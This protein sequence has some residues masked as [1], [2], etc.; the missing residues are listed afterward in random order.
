VPTARNYP[1]TG[2]DQAAAPV[3]ALARQDALELV[4]LLAVGAKHVSDLATAD[5][6][7][8]GGHIDVS[9]DVSAELAHE[10]DAEPSDLRV[11][12]AFG[13]EVGPALSA[14]HHHCQSG[15]ESAL[16]TPQFLANFLNSTLPLGGLLTSCEGILEYLLEAKEFEA[17][18]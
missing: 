18:I 14:A 5:T 13:V 4:S 15:R 3:E 9:A 10:G 2:P 6:N 16:S 1:R 12:L 11:R 7:V 8:T 17:A